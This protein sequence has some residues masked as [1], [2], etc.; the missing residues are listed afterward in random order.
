MEVF[1]IL[2]V[3]MIYFLKKLVF[4]DILDKLDNFDRIQKA[5]GTTPSVGIGIGHYQN[6]MPTFGSVG[7]WHRL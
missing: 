4:L 6:S 1:G 7:H 3:V 5:L 2:L